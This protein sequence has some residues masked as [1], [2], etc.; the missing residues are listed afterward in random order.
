MYF[1]PT[2]L[3]QPGGGPAPPGTIKS[4]RGAEAPTNSE[5]N[6]RS[7]LRRGYMN[8]DRGS[9]ATFPNESDVL[10]GGGPF[11]GGQRQI[12]PADRDRMTAG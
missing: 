1:F 6:V 11:R 8:L 10:I 12:E 3:A 7:R 2:P 4:R 5:R 9:Q